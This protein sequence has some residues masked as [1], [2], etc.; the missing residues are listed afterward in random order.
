LSAA[1]VDGEF[2][3]CNIGG[4][5]GGKECHR[6]RDFFRLAE[7]LRRNLL[8]QGLRELLGV[9]LGKAE[10]VEKGRLDR[11]GA[12]GVDADFRPISSEASVRVKLR[13]AAFE[14]DT[15]DVPATPVWSNQEVV[16][17]IAPLSLSRGNA[18]WT[19]KYAARKLALTMSSN[20]S[21]VVSATE[22]SLAMPALA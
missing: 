21:S 17:T 13:S 7:P 11:A 22:P 5:V 14:A 1:A 3:A 9:G 2:N 6:H 10:L 20:T 4:I 16:K 18:F 12:D 15:A 19:V 8:K